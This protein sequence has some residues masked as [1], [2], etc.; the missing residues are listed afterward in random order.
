[1][2][3]HYKEDINYSMEEL[4]SSQQEVSIIFYMQKIFPGYYK[5][6]FSSF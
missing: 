6:G 1:M 3:P 4:H 2:T 5:I